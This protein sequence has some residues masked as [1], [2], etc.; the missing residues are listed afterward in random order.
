MTTVRTDRPDLLPEARDAEAMLIGAA[1]LDPSQYDACSMIV[2]ADDFEVA[3]HRLA[4]Q[5]IGRR[6]DAAQAV[7]YALVAADVNATGAFDTAGLVDASLTD[8]LTLVPNYAHAPEYAKQVAAASTR[9]KIIAGAANAAMLAH[10]GGDDADSLVGDVLRIFEELD[11]RTAYQESGDIRP[12]LG[13]LESGGLPRGWN[14]GVSCYDAWTPGLRPQEVHTIAGYTGSGKTWMMCQVI[15][16]LIDQ[17]ARVAVFSLEMPAG[18]F[19]PRLLANRAGSAALKWGRPGA[20]FEPG[21]RERIEDAAMIL[22]EATDAGHLSVYFEQTNLAQMSAIVR[23]RGADAMF[24]DYMQLMDAPAARMQE[25]EAI[26]ANATGLQRLAKKARCTVVMLSQVNEDHQRSAGA[27]RALGLKG[28]GAI[29]AVSDIVLYVQATDEP[30]IIK[31]SA[32]KARHGPDANAG[33]I[34]EMKMD[35]ASG[36][37]LPKVG[38]MVG[39]GAFSD[40]YI[41]HAAGVQ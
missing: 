8:C 35:K 2:G 12:A 28:S 36:K 17:G 31:L 14:S 38:V 16:S 22:S 39:A 1:L 3:L 34:A 15:N 27:S 41:G 30:G 32:R 19:L 18:A 23:Q 29:G 11:N 33:S 7:D 37:L 5:A 6:R 40:G 25:Y 20:T 9:R 13:V 24:V 26:T 4:W 10:N 21:E